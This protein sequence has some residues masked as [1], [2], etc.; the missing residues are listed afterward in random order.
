MR[1]TTEEIKKWIDSLESYNDTK[2]LYSPEQI[3]RANL[4]IG[5]EIW[6]PKANGG[7]GCYGTISFLKTN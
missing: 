4:E 3:L 6:I 5:D 2:N 1:F 7:L